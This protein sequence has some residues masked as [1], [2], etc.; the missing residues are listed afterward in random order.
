LSASFLLALALQVASGI[1][2]ELSPGQVTPTTKE[3]VCAKPWTADDPS[4]VPSTLWQTVL[5]RYGVAW[6]DRGQYLPALVVP[7]ALGGLMTVENLAPLPKQSVWNRARKV[8]VEAKVY[9]ELCAGRLHVPEA[10][11]KAGVQWE[12]TWRIYFAP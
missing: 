10:Q 6:P 2:P 12:T 11:Q 1:R 4:R 3:R 5:K 7:S 8:T 9:S